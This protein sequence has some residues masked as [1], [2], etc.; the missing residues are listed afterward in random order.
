MDVFEIEIGMNMKKSGRLL[1][2]AF[3]RT[4]P[5]DQSNLIRFE[6]V[7]FISVEDHLWVVIACS[8]RPLFIYQS[9]VL[10]KRYYCMQLSWIYWRLTS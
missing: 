10:I 3:I 5:S 4:S 1:I 6:N 7:F 9:V 2:S 8:L